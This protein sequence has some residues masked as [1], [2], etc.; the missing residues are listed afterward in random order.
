[1][2]HS[3][4]GRGA[5]ATHESSIDVN[6]LGGIQRGGTDVIGII[7]TRDGFV[8]FFSV[9]KPFQVLV[10]GSGVT[11][12][13]EHVFQI[14]SFTKRLSPRHEKF[15]VTHRQELLTGFNRAALE[16]A[17]V[18]LIGAGGMGS[19][20][21]EALVRKGA[22]CLKIFDPDTIESSNL[23]R[24]MFF[25][26]DVHKKK[27]SRLAVN[28]APHATCGTILEGYDL[29]FRDALVLG[30]DMN[31]S[32]VVC[33]VDNGK[34]RVEV[35]NYLSNAWYSCCFCRCGLRRGK[36][37]RFRARVWST[38][39]W[40]FVSEITLW[41]QSSVLHA[42]GQGHLESHGGSGALRN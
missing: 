19:E 23:N 25:K 18:A 28:L 9:E 31:A 17:T 1:M 13:E 10:Q 3:H 30:K 11:Q 35:S 33:G 38:L 20:I 32:V 21:G 7:V 42:C 27:A 36:R 5:A 41:P 8:R 15:G 14:A 37:L 22:G 26:T 12:I 34:T 24:Q 6:Y 39:F 29:S 4:P 40:L 16:S 2:A